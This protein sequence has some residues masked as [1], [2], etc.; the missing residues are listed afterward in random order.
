[1]II[2]L[3]VAGKSLLVPTYTIS[4]SKAV[5]MNNFPPS[6]QGLLKKSSSGDSDRIY[7]PLLPQIDLTAKQSL[8][9]S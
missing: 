5:P 3:D 9:A 4:L 1:M 7:S 6:I 8:Q 2:K